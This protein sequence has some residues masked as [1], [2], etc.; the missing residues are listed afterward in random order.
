MPLSSPADVLKILKIINI[1]Q[2]N[3]EVGAVVGLGCALYDTVRLRAH[4]ASNS[5]VTVESFFDGKM[6]GPCV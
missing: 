4:P 1:L 3:H 5:V 6:A 2:Y